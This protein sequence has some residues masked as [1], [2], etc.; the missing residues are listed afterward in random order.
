MHDYSSRFSRALNLHQQ[1][2]LEPAYAEYHGLLRTNPRDINVLNFLG[3]LCFQRGDPS[4]AA[5]CL[6]K[7]IKLKPDFAEAH[8]NLGQ[9]LLKSDAV[10]SAIESLKRAVALS[11]NY[12]AAH[13]ALSEAFSVQ[14]RYREAL[15]HAERVVAI[16]PDHVAGW[17]NVG[18]MKFAL[19]DVGAALAACDRALHLRQGF[20][21]ALLNRA[22]FCRA[23]GDLQQAVATFRDVVGAY[24]SDVEVLVEFCETLIEAGRPDDAVVVSE[25]V[26]KLDRQNV[27]AHLLRGR[28]LLSLDREGAAEAFAM[29]CDLAPGAPDA[30]MWLG[31]CRRKY[32]ELDEAERLFMRAAE[33]APDDIQPKY[34]L[35]AL[36]GDKGDFDRAC[37]GFDDVLAMSPDNLPAISGKLAVG[38]YSDTCDAEENI[39]LARE[40]GRL[41][42]RNVGAPFSSWSVEADP[43]RLKVGFVSGDLREHSVGHF[44]E[45]F[46]SSVDQ[47]RIQL[48]AY[49]T[50]R[51]ADELTARILPHFSAWK[52]LSGMTDR[53]AAEMIRADGIHVL[54]DLSGHSLDG[55]LPV[56]A[57][58]PAPVQ[59]CWLGYCATTGL[60]AMGYYLADASTLPSELEA[61]FVERVWRMPRSYL[62]FSRPRADIPVAPLP[63]LAAGRVTFGSFNNLS[64]IGNRVVKVWSDVLHAVPN[65]RL[66]IKASQL[67]DPEACRMTHARFSACGVEPGR[68]QLL[69]PINRRAE[70]LAAYGAVDIALDTFPYNG[71]T[72]TAEALW[73]GV[74]VLTLAGSRFLSR[75]GMGIL[76]SAGLGDWVATDESVFV[77]KAAAFSSTIE[78][79]AETRAS[80]RARLSRSAVFQ[81]VDFAKDFENA[82][83]EMW[84]QG[85]Q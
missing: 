76:E 61:Q 21:P 9:G 67:Q 83:W 2:L 15:I 62:C 73:M 70:H 1:G 71:V 12:V 46:L 45:D 3:V 74:P 49:P 18:V 4:E 30:L 17:V 51:R 50:H 42:E 41:V 31:E 40:Y 72:T 23:Q 54:V 28:S 47:S 43:G 55:R 63:A 11:K 6:K 82:M 39:R 52:P 22:R 48:Y 8:Y 32:G 20:P 78:R 56:F 10:P 33:L 25:H 16:S 69:G 53:A 75:Q 36:Y 26:L 84:R 79:L 58:R 13:L 5:K 34:S 37:Q 44:L 35:A 77:E 66:I 65:S 27:A 68:V 14:K 80:M 38:L 29:A 60:S 81:P 7:C 19:G 85:G 57:L 64:K 24:G 59:C